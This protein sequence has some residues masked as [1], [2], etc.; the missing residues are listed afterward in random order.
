MKKLL[1]PILILLGIG[2]GAGGGFVLRPPPPEPE[3]IE[4][5]A[6]LEETEEEV[7]AAFVK[8]N[9]Q[10]IIPVVKE[11]RVQALVVLSLSLETDA[12]STELIYDREPK[13]R[14]AFLRVLFDHAYAGGFGGAF[15]SSPTLDLLRRSLLE[16]ANQVIGGQV[17]DILITDITRQ[18]V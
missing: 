1:V 13:L 9:N 4:E 14:D 3:G 6:E 8:I 7:E 5:G 11:D 16:A 15:T 18:D 10:F 12:A 17:T 2:G